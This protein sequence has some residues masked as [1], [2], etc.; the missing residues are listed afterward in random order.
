MTL[1]LQGRFQ[2][3]EKLLVKGVEAKSRVLGKEH[4]NTLLAVASLALMYDQQGRLQQAEDLHLKVLE[5]WHTAE[6]SLALTYR[7]QG[8]LKEAEALYFKA[9]EARSRVL[10]EKPP[11][12][13]TAIAHVKKLLADTDSEPS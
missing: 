10:G 1:G 11:R 3:A 2:E 7:K 8:Q 9:V 12:T 4:P 6:L 13:L 5:A